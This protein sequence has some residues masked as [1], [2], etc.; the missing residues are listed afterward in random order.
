MNFF[1]QTEND[2]QPLPRHI[3]SKLESTKPPVI[4]KLEKPVQ[5][6]KRKAMEHISDDELPISKKINTGD[7]IPLEVSGPTKFGVTPLNKFKKALPYSH[8]AAANFKTQ[9][10]YG[11][12][13]KRLPSEKLKTIKEKRK[14]C[15]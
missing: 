3:V 9:M 13:I 14:F 8:H 7:Y 12:R 2:I 6:L 1:L 4:K 11:D 10:L 5:K 15:K